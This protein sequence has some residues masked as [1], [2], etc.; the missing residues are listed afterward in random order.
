METY[1]TSLQT[2]TQPQPQ[3]QPPSVVVTSPS[4]PQFRKLL[5]IKRKSRDNVSPSSENYIRTLSGS[6]QPFKLGL[7]KINDLF[8]IGS[9]EEARN[10]EVLLKHNINC[11]LNLTQNDVLNTEPSAMIQCYNCPLSLKSF[12]YMMQSLPSC[13][14]YLENAIDNNHRIA[15]LC[16]DGFTKALNLVIAFYIVKYGANYED[17]RTQLNDIV[18]QVIPYMNTEYENH[19]QKMATMISFGS[20]QD[21]QSHD[22]KKRISRPPSHSYRLY[23][24]R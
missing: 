18:P 2:L 20:T 4:L 24:L 5:I 11:I 16:R 14:T 21:M 17:I 23:N 13:L 8:Y 15:I 10:Q 19:L 7:T 12:C 9:V 3:Q 1:H 22:N 6:S